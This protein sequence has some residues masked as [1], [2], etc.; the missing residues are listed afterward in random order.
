[1]TELKNHIYHVKTIFGNFCFDENEKNTIYRLLDNIYD[2]ENGCY[3]NKKDEFIRGNVTD[4]GRLENYEN[5]RPRLSKNFVKGLENL[6]SIFNDKMFLHENYY[7]TKKDF[8]GLCKNSN[9]IILDDVKSIGRQIDILKNNVPEYLFLRLF[10]VNNCDINSVDFN[11]I[12]HV[13][14]IVINFNTNNK[15]LNK[16][17]FLDTHIMQDSISKQDFLKAIYDL[18]SDKSI[19]TDEIKVIV[20]KISLGRRLI[21]NDVITISNYILCP[22][23]DAIIEKWIEIKGSNPI[24]QSNIQQFKNDSQLNQE[25]KT[26]KIE[27]YLYDQQNSYKSNVKNLQ[28]GEQ[29]ILSIRDHCQGEGYCNAWSLFFLYEG[30]F[31]ITISPQSNVDEL[32]NRYKYIYKTLIDNNDMVKFLLIY[33][34]W[35]DLLNYNLTRKMPTKQSDGVI[36]SYIPW[37]M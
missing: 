2:V 37:H 25:E 4:C 19:F 18:F 6:K 24:I 20:D 22:Y 9:Q 32:Y 34:F 21:H 27:R 10:M 28:R 17:I 3:D 14:S 29:F 12:Y 31:F 8:Y 35:N 36:Q 5:I 11:N 13:F 26:I 23:D 30:M 1:M 7:E 33:K 16:I 15:L